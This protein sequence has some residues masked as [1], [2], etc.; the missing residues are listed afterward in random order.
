MLPDAYLSHQTSE[1]LRLKIPSKKGDIAYFSSLRNEF[2]KNQG[3]KGVEVN[4]LT[5][6]VLFI[7]NAN[8]DSI[9]QHAEAKSL[10]RLVEKIGETP[11]SSKISEA[12]KDLNNQVSSFTGRELDIPTLAF[13]GL[14]AIGIFQISRGN[15]TAPAWYTAFWYALNIF[16][17]AQPDKKDKGE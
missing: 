11:V 6:S 2:S 15:F 4:P 16:I 14:L 9:T 12:F 13:L 3:I 17:K 1:R 10:F 5:G 7:H 8:K